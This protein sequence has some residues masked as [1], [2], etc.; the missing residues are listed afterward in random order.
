MEFSF[1]KATTN[2]SK[3]INVPVKG[4]SLSFTYTKIVKTQET[5]GLGQGP[6]SR[7]SWLLMDPKEGHKHRTDTQ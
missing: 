1:K 5:S 7:K 4:L 3:H 2:K 6:L